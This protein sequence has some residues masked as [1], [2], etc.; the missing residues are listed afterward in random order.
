MECRREDECEDAHEFDENVDG[1]TGRIFE[2]IAD[3]VTDDSGF[4]GVTTFA[5]V[6][7]AFDVFLGIIP[8]TT[9]IG[10]ED[11]ENDTGNHDADEH[12]T[13]NGTFCVEENIEDTGTDGRDDRDDAGKN[14][15]TDSSMRRNGNAFA[16]FSFDTFFAFEQ[17]GDF[18]ELATDFLHHILSGAAD[19]EHGKR[20]E[21]EGKDA[22]DEETDDDERI[23]GVDGFKAHDL[24]ISDEER[25]GSEGSRTNGEAFAD[26]SGGVT[27]AVEFVCAVT[28][29]FVE[30]GHF[31]DTAGVVGDWTISVNGELDTGC[32]EHTEC[33]ESDTVHTAE[34]IGDEDSRCN[35][36]DGDNRGNHTNGEA[37]DDV[38]SG[39]AIIGS[40]RDRFNGFICIRRIILGNFADACA[41]DET[42]RDR[43]EDA[44]G[45]DADVT[46]DCVS[47]QGQTTI[48]QNEVSDTERG[49]S[50]NDS[51]TDGTGVEG[52]LRIGIFVFASD[53]EG[54]GDAQKD[55]DGSDDQRENDG[56]HLMGGIAGPDRSTENG[57]TD[58]G[59]DVGFEEV[60]AHTGDV[61]DVVTDVI[62][63]GSGVTR[64]VF[65]DTGFDF[66]D[67]VGADVSS[68]CVD[69][70]AAPCEECDGGSTE[71]KAREDFE[72]TVHILGKFS[73]K[74]DEEETDDAEKSEADDGHTHDSAT[75][76]GDGEGFS[77]AR[78]GGI[79]SSDVCFCGDAHTEVTGGGTA[80]GTD[81]VGNGDEP[82]AGGIDGVDGAEDHSND[83]NKDDED[84]VFGIQEGHCAF[85]D[86]TG[87][88][89]HLVGT[90]I[91]FV[92]PFGFE[93]RVDQSS[94]CRDRNA[95]VHK[96]LNGRAKRVH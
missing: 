65:G 17:A 49:D 46:A 21:P 13:Q 72:E 88:F 38:R 14:H 37:L 11:G 75:A 47:G 87:N 64:I 76:K 4:M 3:G 27:D 2:R 36:D 89:F 62:G 74:I 82:A 91:L 33:C 48:G 54:A 6:I 7:S 50:G 52:F 53:D 61:T 18:F 12:T 15:L 45:I 51:G 30:S 77:E 63:D 71:A 23:H 44:Q 69:T 66:A 35:E 92:D 32:G 96:V 20:A 41:G 24:G 57:G 93:D 31:G 80:D 22:T 42:A 70:A 29:F 78:P 79:G 81:D 58:D 26:G 55:T 34:Q 40:V 85:V 60:S 25:K 16:V 67:E 9:S 73:L 19:G 59:A 83:G 90:G 86:V 8:C 68:F 43:E 10:H 95:E 1:R 84:F 94:E 39:A 28:D 56:T 5:T